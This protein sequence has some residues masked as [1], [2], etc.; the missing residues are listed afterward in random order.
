MF[1]KLKI[2]ILLLM[3]FGMLCA[4][5]DI[6]DGGIRECFDVM[7]ANRGWFISTGVGTQLY[8]G[9]YDSQT[10][11]GYRFSAAVEGMAGKWITPAIAVRLRAT[12]ARV[13]G[14]NKSYK[15]NAMNMAHMHAD[16]MLDAF[17]FIAGVE[18]NRKFTVLPFIGIGTAVNAGTRVAKF[19]FTAGAQ[20]LFRIDRKINLFAELKGTLMN[21][22]MDDYDGGRSGEGSAILNAGF[23]YNF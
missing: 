15:R 11:M 1:R 7:P 18:E 8:V 22:K 17:S 3:P 16:C 21:D 23:I 2:A 10:D 13:T 4:N 14:A 9:D 19:S 12:A 20:A 5:N 6:S